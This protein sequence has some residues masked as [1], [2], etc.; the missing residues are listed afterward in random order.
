MVEGPY[1]TA[2][3]RGIDCVACGAHGDH[4][5]SLVSRLVTIGG[6]PETEYINVVCCAKCTHRLERLAVAE[7]LQYAHTLQ[8]I[9]TSL[10]RQALSDLL[11]PPKETE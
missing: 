9:A 6:K 2:A 4:Y 10:T 3:I 11:R 7:A 5:L 1:A 8:I